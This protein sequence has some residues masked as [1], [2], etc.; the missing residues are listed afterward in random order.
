M[1]GSLHYDAEASRRLEEA[2]TTDALVAQRRAVLEWLALRPGE[3]V[4]DVGVGPGL[5]AAEMARAVG[6]T[7]LV[8]GIDTS[9]SMLALAAGRAT[10]AEGAAVDLR[11]ADAVAL[12]FDDAAFDVG[13]ATQVLEYV[14]DVPAAVSELWRVLRPGGRVL[15]LDTDWDTVVW[16][17]RDRA[18]TERVLRAWEQHL[19]D[20]HLPRRLAGHLER[21]GFRLDPVRA[22][23]LLDV[24]YGPRT[25]SA[26]LLDLVAAFVVGRDGLTAADVEAWAADLRSLGREYFFSLDRFVFR[27]TRLG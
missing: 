12:P 8:C 4:L 20:P 19:A 10:V 2:Y 18:R 22:F 3:R 13:V 16:H 21:A 26:G 27:G 7:G 14:A 6:P 23:T 25:F 1:G 15:V 9:E 24:G 5:L 11:C 17:S